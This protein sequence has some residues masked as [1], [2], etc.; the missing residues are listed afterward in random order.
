MIFNEQISRKPD[1]YPWTQDFIEAMHN[2]F[3]THREFNF[4]SDKQDFLVNLTDQEQQIIIRALST[5]GQLEISVKKFWAKLGENLPHP[6]L[7]DLG[8]TMAHVEVIHGDAYERLLEVLGIDDNFEKILELDIIKGRVNYLRKHLHKFHEDNKKQFIYSLI[9]FTLFV[10]NIALFSQFYTISYF[11]RF[12]NMLKD[13]NKQVEYTSREECYIEGTEILT[14][15]GWVDFRDINVGDDVAQYTPE[16]LIEFTKVNHKTNKKYTGDVIAFSRSGNKCIVTP[17]H[18]MV[19][20]DNYDNYKKKKAIDLKLHKNIK[21][22][23]SGTLNN[24]GDN[25]LSYE[26]R[27]KIAIQADGS[28]LYWKNTKAEKIKRGKNGGQTHSFA[29]TKDRKKE[30]LEWILNKSNIPYTKSEPNKDNEVIYRITFNH[31]FDYKSFDWVDLKNKSLEWCEDFI[32][33]VVEW[34]GYKRSDSDSIGYSSTNK[35]CIDMVQSIAICAGYATSYYANTKEGYED[36]PCYKLGL[37]KI[38]H[39]PVSHGIKKTITK[40]NGNVYC[41]SVDSGAIIT[42]LDG[43]TFIAG[44]CLHSM[45]GIKIINTIKEEHPDLF[46]E[47]LEKKI[48]HEAKEAVKYECEIIDW[49]VNGYESE[50]LNSNLLKEYIKDRLNASLKEIGY[51]SVFG[52][53]NEMLKKTT[54]FDEQILGNNMTDF[55]NS[56]PVEYSKNSVCFSVDELF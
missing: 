35:S 19:Y 56:R 26:D 22:P 36:S 11:G 55:F 25:I 39:N 33:E 6:S 18:D 48:L 46:D 7:N 5:I 34:D 9:L 44:N 27:L 8:Y 2:G 21:I 38:D 40:Y 3:W 1:H 13:T 37:R 45:I 53:D 52:V 10:E 24:D 23:I 14:P 20:F 28:I 42:R 41:V 49:I 17:N 31:D 51:E 4:Q 54:W 12:K 29:L 16:G 15:K 30:R 50:Y 43:K 32:Q 47:Q